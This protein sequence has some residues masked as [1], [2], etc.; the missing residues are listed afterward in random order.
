MEKHDLSEGTK[1]DGGKLRLDLIPAEFMFALAEILT[2]GAN[3]YAEWN[4]AKGIKYSRVFG[5]LLRHLYAWWG[6]KSAT[7]VSF[8]FGETDS[9]TGKSHLW[10][11]A[12]CIVFLV[13]YEEWRMVDFD[14]R[15]KPPSQ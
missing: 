3:K 2:F 10:H 7:T 14:D 6:G 9:E 1:H 13:C 15:F 11:A 8:L 5:A 4:W 12:C